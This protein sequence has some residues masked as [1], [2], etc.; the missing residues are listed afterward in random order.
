M[1]NE[2][3]TMKTPKEL[4]TIK[5]E[6]IDELKLLRR[7]FLAT[8]SKIE[9]VAKYATSHLIEMK[10][11]SSHISDISSSE[12]YFE[13][14]LKEIETKLSKHCW[15]YYVKHAGLETLMTEKAKRQY[16]EDLKKAPI[17]TAE[18]AE[19]F[20]KNINEK[21]VDTI[22]SLFMETF[23]DLTTRRYSVN[24]E[25]K[26]RNNKEVEAF[27]ILSY[28]CNNEYYGT[29]ISDTSVIN[30]L[31]KIFCLLDNKKPFVYPNRI[32]DN[33]NRND[34][35]D[36]FENDY[37][38]IKLCANRNVHVKIKNIELLKKFNEYCGSNDRSKLGYDI[39]IQT[40]K[41]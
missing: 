29:R 19:A 8:Y 32:S 39:K 35:E 7:Q 41:W 23:E 22:E 13:R 5:N 33:A 28:A 9:S 16:E 10:L 36:K 1:I 37:F 30:S 14:D 6:I 38:S 4:E 40:V 21:Y 24:K 12:H 18:N 27:F 20:L 17:F 34:K 26:Q 11:N 31:E 2:V 15:D 3:S 25:R